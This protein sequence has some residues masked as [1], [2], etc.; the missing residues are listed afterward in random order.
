MKTQE[1]AGT[2]SPP[3][4][5]SWSAAWTTREIV[6]AA[7]LSVAVGVIFWTWGLL[8]ATAFAAIPFP[9]SYALVGVWMIGGLLVPY[10]IRRPGAAV[11]GELVAAFVSMVLVSQ[12][13]AAVLLSGLVQGAAAEAVFAG[14]RYR[15]YST[16]T[17]MVAGAF[18]GVASIVLD[19]FFY[20]YWEAYSPASIAVGAVLVAISGALLGGV[21]SKLAG[22]AL[23]GTGTLSGLA[24]SR[25]R[26]RTR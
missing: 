12:W 26:K 22:D 25:E 20:G 24:I 10:V 1:P 4:T 17:L 15:V 9:A 19:S 13:G 18:A 11:V 7:V 8:W 3:A 14:L 2:K 23:V 16:A 5:G 21:V 6:V